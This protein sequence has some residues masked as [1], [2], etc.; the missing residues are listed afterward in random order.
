MRE[1]GNPCCFPFTF[2]LAHTVPAL[3]GCMIVFTLGEMVAMPVS[4]AYI[5]GLAPPHMRGRYLG[6]FGLTWACG[7]IVGPAIG[8]KLFALEPSALWLTCG[9]LGA[10]AA[11]II[12]AASKTPVAQAG[13][14]VPRTRSLPCDSHPAG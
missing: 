11:M 13:L 12:F 6:A 1:L 7:L 9:A 10:P 5:A 3:T 14:P 4:S 2:H 8:M